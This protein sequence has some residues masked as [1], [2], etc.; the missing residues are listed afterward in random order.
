[1]IG[2]GQVRPTGGY[3]I[4]GRPAPMLHAA[5]Q[6]LQR[7]GLPMQRLP[8][9]NGQTCVWVRQAAE[10]LKN[11]TCQF[12]VLFCHDVNLACCV[13]NK[14][15]G[16]RAAAVWTLSQANQALK[17]FGANLLIVEASGRTYFEYREL[18]RLCCERTPAVCPGDL[19]CLL[20]ELDGH[21]HR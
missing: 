9:C 19:A 12:A 5:L 4:E 2:N 17:Q 13:A 7:L 11:G 1:M 3:G 8:P 10:C 21:A 14:V 20:E 18:L 16:I 15:P 6:S